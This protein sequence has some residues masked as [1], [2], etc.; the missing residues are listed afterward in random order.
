MSSDIWQALADLSENKLLS[1]VIP[2]IIGAGL[3]AWFFKIRDR[4][5]A[6][7]DESF[8]FVSEVA[9]LLNGALS[10]LFGLLRRGGRDPSL[11]DEGISAL[12]VHR[13]STRAK[14][15]ALLQTEEFWR[16]Y[17][18]LMWQLREFVDELRKNSEDAGSAQLETGGA[19][20]EESFSHARWQAAEEIW[21]R[22]NSLIVAGI[23]QALRGKPMPKTAVR[24]H[25]FVPPGPRNV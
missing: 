22:A 9:D 25:R 4:R 17:E 10:P 7:R 6:I 21:K 5:M 24:H 16:E 8:K 11:V 2:V 19:R 20:S 15:V 12:F 18:E 1:G 13:L 3:F 23:D 14:S